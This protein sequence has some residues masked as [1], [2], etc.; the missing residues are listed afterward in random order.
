[1]LCDRKEV[2][3]EKL[4]KEIEEAVSEEAVWKLL[5]RDREERQREGEEITGNQ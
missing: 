3:W 4:R 5:N 1:M 2:R